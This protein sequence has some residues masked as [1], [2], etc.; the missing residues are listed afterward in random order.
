[1][2]RQRLWL[3]LG[4]GILGAAGLTIAVVR[5]RHFQKYYNPPV[6]VLPAD[7]EVADMRACLRE[8]QGVWPAVPEFT[9]PPA[10]VPV[11]LGWLRPA[12][13]RGQWSPRLAER[14]GDVVFRTRNG[15]E[16]RLMFYSTGKNGVVFTTDGEDYFFGRGIN[17]KGGY[18]DGGICLGYAI[19]E[20]YQ[21]SRRKR[22]LMWLL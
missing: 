16:T 4:T 9:V 15:A 22:W 6:F 3:V 5:T 18:V 8:F 21:V 11:I 2:R 1:M 10:H 17:P 20:A 13:Y 7:D 12:E 14:L 19:Q